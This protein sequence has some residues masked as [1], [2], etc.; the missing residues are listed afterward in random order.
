MLAV[1]VSSSRT[2]EVLDLEGTGLTNQSAQVF[3]DMVENYPT[4]LRVLVLAEN[5]ISPELQQQISDLLSEGEEEED[6]DG[7][8][9]GSSVTPR[10]KPAWVPHSITGSKRLGQ[11][12]ST[13]IDI[14]HALFRRDHFY[15]RNR[16]MNCL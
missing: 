4:S 7:E 14:T 9:R 3:L 11:K 10:E 15:L 8:A 1:A 16:N 2:L 13:E 12:G 5:D 6:K